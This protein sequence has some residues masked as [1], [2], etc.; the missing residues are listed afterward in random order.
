MFSST[1][2]I[3]E[4]LP[5]SKS[6]LFN[7]LLVLL[8]PSSLFETVIISFSANELPALTIVTDA[9]PNSPIVIEKMASCPRPSDVNTSV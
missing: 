3:H 4:S 9:S 2:I 6:P 5:D 1:P 8:S 7:R